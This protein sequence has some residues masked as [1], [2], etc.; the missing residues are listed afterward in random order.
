VIAQTEN[1]GSSSGTYLYGSSGSGTV[2]TAPY[3]YGNRASQDLRPRVATTV[4][5]D[6]SRSPKAE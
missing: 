1:I 6:E 4:D 5:I 2:T 3:I